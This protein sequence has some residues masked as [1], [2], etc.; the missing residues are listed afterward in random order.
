MIRQWNGRE[1]CEIS[2]A[3]IDDAD[4]RNYLISYILA[5]EHLY[6]FVVFKMDAMIYGARERYERME[7]AL[8]L[9]R[10]DLLMVMD[11]AAQDEGA[12]RQRAA[13]RRMLNDVTVNAI[14]ASW[15]LMEDYMQATVRPIGRQS[16]P[17]DRRLILTRQHQH[18]MYDHYGSGTTRVLRDI[19]TESLQAFMRYHF[20]K[21]AYF[22]MHESLQRFLIAALPAGTD[23]NTRNAL[24]E[25]WRSYGLRH[26]E[27]ACKRDP[28]H[29]L[30]SN[31]TS[32]V[33]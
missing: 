2:I 32:V 10:N 7:I 19:Q 24:V 33:C 12:L 5:P 16:T 25:A 18:G 31:L 6:G 20:I 26:Y 11:P 21:H 28:S 4:L 29:K 13:L 8:T 30:R 3:K 17:R 27:N 15:P 23:E 22:M 1:I 9:C 14:G